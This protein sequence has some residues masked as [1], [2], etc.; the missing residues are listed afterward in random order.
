MPDSS[1]MCTLLIAYAHKT[2]S[3]AGCSNSSP[4]ITLVYVTPV[5]RLPLESFN[6]LV[7][8]ECVRNSKFG[9][10]IAIGITVMCGLPLAFASQP[11]RSQ[12]P[13]YWHAPSFE[14]S[15]FV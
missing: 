14:P 5:T 6:T 12:N 9:F 10:F 15:G 2:T 7:T 1:M 11:K 8:H 4:F 3:C 13:Q